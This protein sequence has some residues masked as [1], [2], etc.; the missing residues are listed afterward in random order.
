LFRPGQLTL[1][2]INVRRSLIFF[3]VVKLTG[4]DD[5]LADDEAGSTPPARRNCARASAT[6]MRT[7][8][9]RRTGSPVCRPRSATR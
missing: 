8:A 2:Y 1:E 4:H 6:S 7:G 3:A 5:V 9:S